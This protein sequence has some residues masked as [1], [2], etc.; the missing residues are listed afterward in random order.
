LRGV[1]IVGL[2]HVQVAAP[3][4]CEADAR[5]FSGDLLG[6][7]EVTRPE[8]LQA[9]GG[10]WFSI[11]HQQLHIGVEEPFSPARKAHPALRVAP[12]QLDLIAER[13]EAAQA[14]VA[15][16][17]DIPGVRRYYTEDPWGN[18]LELLAHP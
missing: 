18:R 14:K 7:V 9:R 12:E 5:R 17:N 8:A 13:L 11:G 10:V 4:G 2:D 16:D 1:S 6:L 15:W 3:R